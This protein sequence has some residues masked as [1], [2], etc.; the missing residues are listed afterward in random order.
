MLRAILNTTINKNPGNDV[1][2]SAGGNRKT[3]MSTSISA[4]STSRKAEQ[5]A[6]F[7]EATAIS[8]SAVVGLRVILPGR[9]K[10]RLDYDDIAD[11]TRWMRK[12]RSHNSVEAALEDTARLYRKSLWHTA[13]DYV[14]VW[15]E[16]DAL[17]GVIYPIT[18]AL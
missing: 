18:F 13:K 9:R 17:A 16:K 14:E 7:E 11:A 8:T 5:L 4:L 6:L 12:P 1:C 2:A 15:V 10:G 3:L